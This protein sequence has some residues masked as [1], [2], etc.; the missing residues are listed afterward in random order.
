MHF[1]GARDGAVA[2]ALASHLCAPSSN[3]GVDAIC[4][5]SLLLVLSFAA[6]DFSPATPV[7]PSSKIHIC[8]FQFNQES[9]RQRCATSKLL[10]LLLLSSSLSLLFHDCEKV[11]KMFWFC[12]LFMI[13]VHYFTAVR[14]DA[15]IEVSE[16]GTN[17]NCQL[18][19]YESG[20]F[21]L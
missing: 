11:E 14:R 15:K 13:K 3:P 4:G 9:G 7:F 10:L 19:V 8:K 16:R 2:K 1:R 6:R 21:C 18:K 17:I 12:D 20:T 5:L